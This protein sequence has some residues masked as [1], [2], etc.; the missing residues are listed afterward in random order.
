M[1]SMPVFVCKFFVLFL[2]LCLLSF[3]C[4]GT[5]VGNP[6]FGGVMGYLGPENI[7]TI[8]QTFQLVEGDDQ[9]LH[10]LSFKV[11]DIIGT[12]YPLNFGVYIYE[13]DGTKITG[14]VLYE[15][16]ELTTSGFGESESFQL[17]LGNIKL[18][19]GQEYIW[20]LSVSENS[21][22]ANSTVAIWMSQSYDN[23]GLVLIDNEFDFDLLFQDDWD[24]NHYLKNDLAFTI[25]L[26]AIPEPYSVLFFIIAP[27][28]LRKR[29]VSM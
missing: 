16:E 14:Q 17:D 15:S 2:S 19:I 23:G 25:E 7:S 13:W 3:E 24:K 11:Y 20:F 1:K 8:G 5:I 18:Q 26:V 12:S 29:Y 6:P 9:Y 22:P 21:N 10:S 27:F 4:Q 28:V